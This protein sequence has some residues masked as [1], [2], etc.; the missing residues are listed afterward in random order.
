MASVP[1]SPSPRL[2]FSK[3]SKFPFRARTDKKVKSPNF[4]CS[5]RTEN[6]PSFILSIDVGTSGT[7]VALVRNDGKSICT[8]FCPHSSVSFGSW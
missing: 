7:K 3:L 5:S 2:R 4:I 8:S 1:A 6:V